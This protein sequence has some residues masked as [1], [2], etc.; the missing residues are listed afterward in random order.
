MGVALGVTAAVVH[1]PIKENLPLTNF[2]DQK[3][4]VLQPLG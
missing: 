4:A 3:I 1:W 2:D